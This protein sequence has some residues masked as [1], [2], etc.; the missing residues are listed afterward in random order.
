M[1]QNNNVSAIA[2]FKFAAHPKDAPLQRCFK[3][4]YFYTLL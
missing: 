3:N 4:H 2:I 1:A